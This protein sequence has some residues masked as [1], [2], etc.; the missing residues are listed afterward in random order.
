M[1][2][3]VPLTGPDLCIKLTGKPDGSRTS[4]YEYRENKACHLSVRLVRARPESRNSIHHQSKPG[5]RNNPARALTGFDP[6][7]RKLSRVLTA[8]Q[9]AAVTHVIRFL[10]LQDLAEILYRAAAE[11]GYVDPSKVQEILGEGPQSK[12]REVEGNVYCIR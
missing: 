11:G 1:G 10:L 9:P 2:A 5:C 8:R 3:P 4:N 12:R 7:R 6:G